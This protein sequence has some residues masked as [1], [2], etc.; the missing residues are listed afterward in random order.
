MFDI[1]HT[2]WIDHL[3]HYLVFADT[4]VGPDLQTPENSIAAAGAGL[5]T[6]TKL[7]PHLLHTHSNCLT[8]LI[9][10]H[11]VIAT[12][13]CPVFDVGSQPK[14]SDAAGVQMITWWCG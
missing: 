6:N 7:F 13:F 5:K 8:S 2:L 10:H 14:L 11:A 4:L 9:N 1:I 3:I 12:L